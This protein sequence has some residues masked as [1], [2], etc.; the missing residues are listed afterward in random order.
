MY[1]LRDL[2]SIHPDLGPSDI[3]MLSNSQKCAF[4]TPFASN[5]ED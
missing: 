2:E 4:G 5:E 3:H 1:A